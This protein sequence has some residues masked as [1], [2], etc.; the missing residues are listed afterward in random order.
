[1]RSTRQ[2]L[3]RHSFVGRYPLSTLLL[4]TTLATGGAVASCSSDEEPNRL[5]PGDASLEAWTPTEEAGS[6]DDGGADALSDAEPVLDAAPFDAGPRPVE[7]TSAPCA[8]ELVTT[9]APIESDR[10]EGF[11]ALLNDGTVA[12]WGANG[13]GQL[14]RGPDAGTLDSPTAMHVTGLSDIAHLNHTCAIDKSGGAW[15]WGRGPFLQND[16]GLGTSESAPV[17]LALPAAKRVAVGLNVGCA[18]VDDGVLC[19]GRNSNAQLAPLSEANISAVFLPRPMS[20]PSGAP[21]RD[22][23]VGNG[24]F[25]VREDGRMSTWGARTSLARATPLTPDP[26]P[27]DI[28]LAGISSIDVTLDNGCATV[29]GVGYCW[30]RAIVTSAVNS[31]I[32]VLPEAVATPEPIVQISTTRAFVTTELG[33]TIQRPQRWCAVGV[34]GDVYCWGYNAS[35]QAGDGTKTDAFDRA[36]KVKGLPEPANQ[37]RTMPDATCALLTNGKVYCWGSNNNGQLGNGVL[38]APSLVPQE[39]VLP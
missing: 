6:F 24:S 8:T 25:A 14:G 22:V 16:A 4:L 19:W 11:C 29:A 23:F 27:T 9:F 28:Q 17:K 38:R 36:V 35:G 1:M 31:V 26:Y 30:G 39:V 13:Y 21:V 32:R 10:S 15:C 34:S 20:F 7:C 2:R 33:D 12:C 37:V 5:D 18:V 3:D